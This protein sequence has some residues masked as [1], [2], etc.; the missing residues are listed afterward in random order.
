MIVSICC[1]RP[2]LNEVIAKMQNLFT[3]LLSYIVSYDVEAFDKICLL[4]YG[5]LQ[6]DGSSEIPLN[7][8]AEVFFNT[9]Q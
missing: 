4:S 2:D 9:A 3:Y 1:K 5:S 8:S 7:V 6:C